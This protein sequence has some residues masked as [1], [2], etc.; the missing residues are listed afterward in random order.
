MIVRWAPGIRA[1]V[2]RVS[3]GVHEKS[4]SPVRR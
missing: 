2:A 3:S 1:A 4:Y